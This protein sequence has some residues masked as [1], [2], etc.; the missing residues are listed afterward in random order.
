MVEIVWELQEN[1]L[2]KNSNVEI[3]SPNGSFF[4]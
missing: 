2:I 3:T 4:S 1:H